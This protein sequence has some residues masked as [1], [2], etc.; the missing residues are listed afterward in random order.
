[1]TFFPDDAT[2]A[3]RPALIEAASGA[4]WSHGQLRDAVRERA[5]AM[6]RPGKSLVF[7]LC[8]NDAATVMGYL[9]ALD[10]GHAVMLLDAAIREDVLTDLLA[11]Y[12]PE[13][14]LASVALEA[15][16]AAALG[17]VYRP[18]TLGWE[19]TAPEPSDAPGRSVHPDLAILLT[20]SGST[21]SPKF[22]RIATNALSGN[23]Q[24]IAT[25]LA[26]APTDRAVSSLPFHYSYGLSVLNS[27]LAAGAAVVLTDRGPL[28]RGFWDVIRD[29]KC[30]SFAGVPY[31][32]QIMER[33]GFERLELPS[34]STMTQA[35]GKLDD[36]RVT[37]FHDLMGSRGGRFFVM[38][39]QT[40]ATAR[41]AILPSDALPEKLGSAGRAVPGGRLEVEV[42]G[43]I[44]K[45][46]GVT[47]EIVYSGPNVMMGY[48]TE[49]ADL[50]RGDDLGGRLRTGDLGY[51]D[52][53]GFLFIGGRTKRISKVSGYRVD[54]DEVEA[55]LAPNGPTAVV[56]SDDL[57]VAWCEYGDDESLQRLRMDLARSL[58]LHH[59]AVQ[60][61]RVDALPRTSSGKVDYAALQGLVR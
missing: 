32:Y 36:G 51:L 19:R 17:H 14:V 38:Y 42:D 9:A 15:E 53:D 12:R 50:A 22:V 25:A 55:R 43:S 18:M 44:V 27:H 8:R 1:M 57:I 2:P 54:L 46:P 58:A 16:T 37:R 6:E 49:R 29:Q 40:E 52:A 41:M 61:R 10:A 28:D 56:G 60:L 45:Q 21:G 13:I 39:G 33:I 47:G 23:A 7:C 31:S 11:R 26:I 30:T 48:A 59:S 24:S 34:L 5:G 4:E 35:G 3:D 20:T